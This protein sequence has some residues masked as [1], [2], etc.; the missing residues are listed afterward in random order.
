MCQESVVYSLLTALCSWH[1]FTICV[2]LYCV[3]AHLYDGMK[4]DCFFLLYKNEI[5]QVTY[6][7]NFELKDE[8]LTLSFVSIVTNPFVL[9]K[10]FC[11]KI[12]M[13]WY[14]FLYLRSVWVS[15]SSWL[16][17]RLYLAYSSQACHAALGRK[18]WSVKHVCLRLYCIAKRF[19]FVQ[20]LHFPAL[21]LHEFAT[22]NFH[23]NLFSPSVRP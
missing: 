20:F 23:S 15:Q 16:I 3:C 1:C 9:W 5:V 19:L 14:L 6:F 2:V 21:S 8:I 10:S 4:R 7:V 13:S 22:F 17:C 12:V 11:I 18:W